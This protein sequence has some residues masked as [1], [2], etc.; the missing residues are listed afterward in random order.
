MSEKPEILTILI[1]M[2]FALILRADLTS[3]RR[4]N[5]DLRSRGVDFHASVTRHNIFESIVP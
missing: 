5:P 3:P 2:D 4:S 1:K